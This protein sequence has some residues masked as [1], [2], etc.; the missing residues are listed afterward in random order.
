MSNLVIFLAGFFAGCAM[1]LVTSIMM[2]TVGR[3]DNRGE[4]WEQRKTVVNKSRIEG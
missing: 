2:L 4:N 1:G 3:A